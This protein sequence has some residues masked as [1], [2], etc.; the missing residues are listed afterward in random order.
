VLLVVD[1]RPADGFM[2]AQ[3]EARIRALLEP[4]LAAEAPAPSQATWVALEEA[5]DLEGAVTAVREHL[6]AA[7]EDGA[8]RLDLVRYLLDLG[9]DEEAGKVA[10]KLTDDDWATEAGVALKARMGFAEHRSD[11][12]A[13]AAGVRASPEDLDLR[14]EYGRALVAAGKHE[15]GLEELVTVAKRDLQHA[16]GAARKAMLEVFEMLGAEDPLTVEYQR[17]LSHLLCS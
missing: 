15:Q 6:R 17:R 3:P 7:P 1:G 11:T 16:D 12:E 9:R 2:G 4:H 10:P 13:L 5:G 8:A 14:L